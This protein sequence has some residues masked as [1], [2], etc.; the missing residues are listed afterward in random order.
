MKITTAGSLGNVSQPLVRL[1][2][3]AGH[4]VTVISSNA[5]KQ[6]AIEAL[7]AKAAIG[8][9]SDAGFLTRAFTGADAVY[10]MT[11]PAMGQNIVE[12][13]AKA[14][15]AYAEA[16]KTSGV[17]RVVML[18][19]IG[20]DVAEGTGPVKGVYEVEQ[21]FRKLHGVNVTFVRAGNFYYN[22]L[23]DIPMIKKD[24]ILGSN[25]RGDD[26]LLLAHPYDIAAAIADE[27]Q[28]E[29][30]DIDVR[31]MISDIS[32]GNEVAAV[33]GKAIGE[34]RLRWVAFEDEQWRQGL[35][36]AGLPAELAGLLTEMGQG[37]KA[38][39]LTRDFLSSGAAV[40]GKIKLEDFAE[41]FRRKF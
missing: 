31:Y 28:R 26:K 1:L 21:I 10:T 18:S 5:D 37:M 32:T 34:P 35:L 12:N 8:S 9:I 13:I 3:A 36:A 24:H 40:T 38:G 16:I 4:D 14:G 27:L 39:L 2:I 19:S 6:S 7:G 30:N 11:P 22:F 15:E 20:A 25:Y 17:K 41:E 29:G 23:R 33:L